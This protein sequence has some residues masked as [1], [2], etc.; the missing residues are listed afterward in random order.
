MTE[1]R[2][3]GKI[4]YK[5]HRGHHLPNLHRDSRADSDIPAVE[6]AQAVTLCARMDDALGAR[7]RVQQYEVRNPVYG[8]YVDDI[9]ARRS[10]GLRRNVPGGISWVINEHSVKR[11]EGAGSFYP[12][13]LVWMVDRF[14][15]YI[16]RS[17]IESE[18]QTVR[19][20]TIC[21]WTYEQNWQIGKSCGQQSLHQMLDGNVRLSG[22]VIR[23]VMRLVYLRVIVGGW[24]LRHILGRPLFT[25]GA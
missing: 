22:R 11:R 18:S 4:P 19:P 2:I 15:C 8:N 23:H 7:R 3:T 16:G 13:Q 1:V 25:E 21:C 14:G 20:L 9:R 6:S 24:E 10:S 12:V 17:V 5:F